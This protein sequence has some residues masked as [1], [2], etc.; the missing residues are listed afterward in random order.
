MNIN[1]N[2]YQIHYINIEELNVANHFS[3]ETII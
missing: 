2:Y 3:K 1:L